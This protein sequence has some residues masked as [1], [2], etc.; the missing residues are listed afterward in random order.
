MRWL[1]AL[2]EI[3]LAPVG[4]PLRFT[5]GQFAVV[6]LEAR[7]GWHRH[8]FTVSSGAGEDVL[9]VTAKALGDCTSALEELV[10]P[11]MP[12][13]IG[14]PPGRFDLRRGTAR[15][16][17]I[18][19]GLGVA[20]FL[21]WIRSP[22]QPSVRG[23]LLLHRRRTDPVP[24]EII[25]TAAHHPSLR[26]HLIGSVSEG[27]LSSEHVLQQLDGDVTDVSLY[28]CGP[29]PMLRGFALDLRRAGV[30]RTRIHREYFEWR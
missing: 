29:E 3:A 28:M 18:A 23:R 14:G 24:D 7:D 4:R 25:E 13:V 27:R 19:A 20:P 15:Q 8:P 16:V 22:G 6:F 21:S 1:L 12:A 11:G 5:S 2:L 10:D 9:R 26:V 17:W 30:R